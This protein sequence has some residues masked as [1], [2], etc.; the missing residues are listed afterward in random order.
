MRPNGLSLHHQPVFHLGI[1]QRQSIQTSLITYVGAA[2]G[3]LNFVLLYPS[4][5]AAEQVGLIRVLIALGVLLAQ[6]SLLGSSLVLQRYFPYFNNPSQK[7]FGFLSYAMRNALVGFALFGVITW[8][9]KPWIYLAFAERSPLLND[10]YVHMYPLALL[11]MTFEVL[12]IYARSLLLTVVPVF[13]KELLLRVMQTAAVLLYAWTEIDFE[14]FLL[15]F[16]GS[17]LLHF[18]AIAAY[19]ALK[20]QLHLF[21]AINVSHVMPQRQLNRYGFFVYL[22]SLSAVYVANID[23]ILLGAKAGLDDA[24]VYAVAFFIGTLV[25]I[26]SRAMNQVALPLVADA[27]KN[28]DTKKIDRLYKQTANNQLIVGGFMVLMILLNTRWVLDLLPPL[29][30][31]GEWVVYVIALGRVLDMATGINGEIILVS[32]HVR[33]NLVTNVVLMVIATVAVWFFIAWFGVLGVALAVSLAYVVYNVIR[34]IFLWQRYDMQPFTPSAAVTA[35]T[36]FI[37]GGFC[38]WLPLALKS[39]TAAVLLSTIVALLYWGLVLRLR[40]SA[41]LSAL[42]SRWSAGKLF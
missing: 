32:R 16:A 10:F 41:E 8:L 1:I 25:V 15:L 23:M 12:F 36:L 40:L 22:V 29:Y 33:F 38:L 4:L 7:H 14:F 30:A 35:A 31:K 3:Y 24:A 2:F 39:F 13:I 28:N 42:A 9:C 19:L 5:M 11:L 27:W 34:M 20:R 6:L 21:A 37:I 17:Y 18:V 26:P